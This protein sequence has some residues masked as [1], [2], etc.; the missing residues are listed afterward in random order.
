MKGYMHRMGRITTTMVALFREVILTPVRSMLPREA[1]TV[2]S[3]STTN[4]R[5]N[6]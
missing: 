1:R 6:T 2:E 3:P 4:R 5:R